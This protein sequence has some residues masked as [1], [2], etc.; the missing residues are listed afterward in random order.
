MD[1]SPGLVGSIVPIW[2]RLGSPGATGEERVAMIA[3]ARSARSGLDPTGGLDAV[4]TPAVRTVATR[5]PQPYA[6][7][8]CRDSSMTVSTIPATSDWSQSCRG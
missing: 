1:A 5:D 6:G 2:G 3:E 4:T 8:G 7:N